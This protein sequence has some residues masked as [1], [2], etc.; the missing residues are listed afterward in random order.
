MTKDQRTFPRKK[1]DEPTGISAGE[2]VFVGTIKD[3]SEGGAA[4]EFDFQSGMEHERFDIGS[5]VELNPEKSDPRSG[6]VVRE[7]VNG[8]GLEFN[9]SE[10]NK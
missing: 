9:P 6:R 10:D 8:V 2:K 5:H 7:Y 1:A 4:V 3:I